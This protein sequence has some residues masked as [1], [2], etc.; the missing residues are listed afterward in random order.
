M[1]LSYLQAQQEVECLLY[2][3]CCKKTQ[4]HEHSASDMLPGGRPNLHCRGAREH[5]DGPSQ[6]QGPGQ[7]AGQDAGQDE[8]SDGWAS[9]SERSTVSI[10][11]E[12]AACA[13]N[14]I[15]TLQ[16]ASRR[17]VLYDGGHFPS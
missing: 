6:G 16:I 2:S 17:G 15:M 8:H 7:D 10:S 12:R 11:S 4:Q 5:R 9:W 14:Q 3:Y 1:A 13:E